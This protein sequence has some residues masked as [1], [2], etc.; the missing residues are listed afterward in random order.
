MRGIS[1]GQALFA[2]TLLALG[3]LSLCSGDFAFVWQPVPADIPGRAVLAYLSGAVLCAASVGLL[4]QRT[5]A[6]AAFVLYIYT[7]LWLL[8]LHVP[9][10]IMAPLHEVNWGAC[11]EI[12]TLVSAS[13]ILY[14]STTAPWHKFYFLSLTSENA[15]RAARLLFALSVPLV[16]L[17]HLVY[18][19]A[20]A[21]MVPAWLPYRMGWAYF[22]GLAHMAAGLAIACSVLPRLA[23][24]LEAVMMG[25]FTVLVWI[26]MVVAAPMQRFDWTGLLM[27]AVMTASAWIVME[28]YRGAAWLSS[29]QS[30]DHLAKLAMH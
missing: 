4:I 19:D 6:L 21:A 11:G 16:G 22:T 10:L 18:S 24:A 13:W 20:T 26:P 3:G 15:I 14:A 29:R 8:V 7:L 1:M 23:A 28:S 2:L 27:S 9:H 25:G 30:R 17:E 12:A 5:T